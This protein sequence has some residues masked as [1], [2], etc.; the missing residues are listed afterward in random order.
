MSITTT[1]PVLAER[2]GSVLVLTLNRPERLNAWNDALE[3]CY[4]DLLLEADADPDVRAIVVTGAG[5]GFCAGADLDDLSELGPGRPTGH[6]ADRRRPRAL[7]LS[8]RTPMIAA[9]NGPVAG[10]GLV[11]ALYCD[12]RFCV[13]DAKITT[14]F[15][16]RGLVAEYGISWILP[17]L[18]G[19]G[20]AL[21]LLLS[22]RVIRGEEAT[23]IGLVE[24][25]AES[26]QLL[27]AAVEYA[28][29]L[30]ESCSPWSMATIKAQVAHDADRSLADALA[31][32]DALILESLGRPDIVEGV[33][34]HI[35]RRPPRFPGL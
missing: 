30:A 35:A 4:F 12:V 34:S 15:A 17:R 13:P 33:A 7:P 19:R 8:I 29:D 20:R 23:A 18:V 24:H 5:R 21:D 27:D 22:G 3:E 28:R 10:I 1:T 6:V 26:A 2:R 14:A 31:A 9:I 25:L 32:S 16:R 11:E